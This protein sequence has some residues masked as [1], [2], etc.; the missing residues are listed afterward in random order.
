[1]SI[2]FSCTH[3]VQFSETDMA[4][5]VHFSNFFRWMEEVEYAFFRSVGLSVHSQAKDAALVSWPRV[6]T[7]CNF[8]APARFEDIVMLKL[9]ITRVGEK[10]LSYEVDFL[11]DQKPIAKAKLTSVCCSVT[12]PSIPPIPIPT[13]IRAKPTGQ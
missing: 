3:P 5:V 1:M 6:S 4:G 11:I 8:L 9:R 12:P 2:E 13:N 10:S 7:S